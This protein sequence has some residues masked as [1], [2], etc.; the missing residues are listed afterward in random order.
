M[1]SV[2]PKLKVDLLLIY[3]DTTALWKH[4]P[5]NLLLKFSE[6]RATRSRENQNI[7]V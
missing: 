4:F 6:L 2:K 3:A 7:V 5:P 1:L